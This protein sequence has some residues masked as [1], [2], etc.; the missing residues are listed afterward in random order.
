MAVPLMVAG[1]AN[2][3]QRASSQ[4]KS[5]AGKNAPRPP[6]FNA[7]ANA[8]AQGSQMSTV[9]PAGQSNTFTTNPDGSTTLNSGFQGPLAGA[10]SSLQNQA[11]A[12]FGQPVMNGDAARQQAIDA[13]FSDARSRLDPL[14][15]QQEGSLNQRLANQGLDPSSEAARNA[16]TQFGNQRNDAYRGA[17]FNAISQGTAAGDSVF[18]NNLAARQAPLSE[19]AGLQGL[20]APY[21]AAS[22]GSRQGPQTL[23]AALGQGN[24]DLARWQ[25][26]QQNSADVFGGIGDAVGGIVSG[27]AALA[28]YLLSDERA[29]INV[30]RYAVDVLPGVPLASWEYAGRPGEFHAGVVAQDLERVAPQFVHTDANGLKWVDYSFLGGA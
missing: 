12:N 9:G 3:N 11:A 22:A 27:G 19:L 10:M 18:R 15:A 16:T 2:A 24:L 21:F 26:Q 20:N 4:P 14:F 8:Q 28:P 30:I 13:A 17:L 6:D 29:K 23:A 5:G 25:A 1:A 7:A